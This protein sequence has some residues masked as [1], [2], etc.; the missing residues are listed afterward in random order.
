[1]R[2]E[3]ERKFL[4]LGDGWRQCAGPASLLRQA[5]LC[6]NENISIRVRTSEAGHASLTIKSAEAGRARSEFDYAIPA[7]EALQLLELR[8][9]SIVGKRRYRVAHEGHVWEIDE[10]LGENDGLVIA[11][12]EL[13]DPDEV[14]S[15]PS[16]AGR[17]VTDELQ[18]FNASL[19][20]LPFRR[21]GDER[22]G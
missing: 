19:A 7:E 1:M 4:V 17:E 5:Y 6:L 20:C 18:Y 14:F 8:T 9:G 16:W 3:I 21:W 2:L 12:V 10:F 13:S 22:K 15:K 11:E